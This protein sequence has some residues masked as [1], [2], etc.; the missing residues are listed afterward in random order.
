MSKIL[1]RNDQ[2]IM[3][4]P[5]RPMKAMAKEIMRHLQRDEQELSLVFVNDASIAEINKE[6][7]GRTGPTNVISFDY[8]SG[9]QKDAPAFDNPLLG[10]IVVSVE[11][12]AD[13]AR[14]ADIPA[15]EEVVFCVIHG[16]AHLHGYDHE[17]VGDEEVRAMELF[18]KEIFLRFGKLVPGVLGVGADG[19]SC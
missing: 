13:N 12:C 3:R 5:I 19:Q 9:A 18:E 16:I 1:V 2:K 6:F 8:G 7:L 10:E 15:I 4:L 17:D 14:K 11:R